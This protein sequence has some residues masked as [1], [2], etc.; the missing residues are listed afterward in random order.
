LESLPKPYVA[1]T[2]WSESNNIVVCLIPIFAPI[3]FGKKS[4]EG[5]VF[6]DDFVD[7]MKAI[8]EK[9]GKWADLMVKFY[10]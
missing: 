7:K 6:D 9:H 3:F 8:S 4:I 2:T 1:S 5:S 10:N